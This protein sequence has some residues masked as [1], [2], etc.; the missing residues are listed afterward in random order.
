[1][2]IGWL[3]LLVLLYSGLAAQQ[4]TVA[5]T[6]MDEKSKGLESA[7]IQLVSL[8]DSNSKISATSDKTGFFSLQS[9]PY[10]Y[11]RLRLSY[12]SL[13]PMTIDSLHFRAERFDF[14]LNEIVLKAK[15][16]SSLDEIIIYA[17]KPLIQSKDGN[18]TFNAGES[19]L[20][21]GSNASD[22]LTQVPLVTKDP[23][24]KVLVRGKEP[25]I[26]IDDKP[27]ELNLQ[28]LQD[29]LESL[30]GS[31]IEKIEVMTNP[32][33][34]YAN[35]QGGVINITTRKGTVGMSGRL[36]LFAGSRGE[37][38]GNGSFS[39]RKNGFA[40]NINA[41]LTANEFNG[42]GYS[43]RQ[44]TFK[45]SSNFFRTNNGY[46]NRSLRPN[47]RVN[48]DY[49]L[50]KSHLLNF[51]FQYNQN[52]FD[53]NNR[54]TYR[55]INRFDQ[56]YRLSQRSIASNGSSHNPNL[57]F[58]YT[59]KT[60]TPGEVFRLFS[61]YNYSEN[62]NERLF[63]QQF[64]SPDFS[65]T[66]GNDSTQWQLTDNNSNGYNVRISYDRPL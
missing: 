1:M 19:A 7:T 28:Q 62:D 65:Y 32:P 63:Y 8:N 54:T 45:D 36:S 58:T 29:L 13:Q 10:G 24:G 34:Q 53:N 21:Q 55:N 12:V 6:V 16:Q 9:I 66:P 26:L 15:Q 46:G 41:G 51:V 59:F 23:D 61:N 20:S 39:Y 40:M 22:L 17:E 30:P 50:T 2:R 4:G 5:G 27:V 60:K 25:K 64:F 47:L 11:Y 44:N 49:E 57:S 38:G 43:I 37:V 48:I 56:V 31:A 35:E 42:E 3:T 33:P 14:N 52:R 18:I